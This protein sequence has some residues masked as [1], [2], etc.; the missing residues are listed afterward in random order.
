MLAAFEG[1]P[2]PI[3]RQRA[4][5]EPIYARHGGLGVGRGPGESFAE[6]K[7]D[8]PHIRDFLLD[9]EVIV[10][11]SEAATTWD[12]IMPL[13]HAGAAT[14]REALGRGDR[15]FWFGCHISHSYRAG[16]SLYYTFGFACWRDAAG[17]IDPWAELDHFTAV[18]RAGFD[19][20]AEPAATLAHHHAV[21]YEHLPWLAAEGTI[22]GASAVDA[23]KAVF[24][25]HGVMNPGK[26]TVR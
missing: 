8:F 18:K 6:G 14:F 20:F 15:R 2:K 22:G 21:G 13:Y 4:E 23:V 11:V 1:T 19:C 7:F 9:H 16:A 3:A 10:D 17:D 24:D 26:L 5:V 25:P 12:K